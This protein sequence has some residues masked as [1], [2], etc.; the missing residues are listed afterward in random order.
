MI[1]APGRHAR[2]ALVELVGPAGAGKST[3][4]QSLPA[5]DPAVTS[6]PAIWGL[7]RRL[8]ALSALA[9]LPLF[10][11]ALLRGRPFA[12]PEMAQMIR[13]DALRR[14]V[15]RR[16]RGG[17]RAHVLDEG[18]VFGLSWLEVFYA[19]GHDQARTQWR[20]RMTAEWAARLDAV[21]RLDAADGEI[22]RRI[23]SRAKPHMVKHLSDR[24]IR[25]VTERFREAFDRIL[26]QMAAGGRVTVH[27]V[28][29]SEGRLD[30]DTA[31][32]H[33]ALVETV[34]DA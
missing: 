14:A 24:D 28:P 25:E 33:D 30:A 7:P 32:V 2:P 13:L 31:R 29:S 9:L 4:A 1:A 15:S 6:G 10:T 19:N 23:R 26:G 11:G 34:R 8:L 16:Q 27:T 18:P 20:R 17:H 5:L 3:V 22:A 21:V 12:P